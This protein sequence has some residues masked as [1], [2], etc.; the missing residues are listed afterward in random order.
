MHPV[1][2]HALAVGY[3]IRTL[4]SG[5]TSSPWNI[6]FQKYFSVELHTVSWKT[7]IL[8]V[9]MQGNFFNRLTIKHYL[10]LQIG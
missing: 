2:V 8:P 4:M 1:E 3:M 7:G 9:K 10:N 6:Q 5:I